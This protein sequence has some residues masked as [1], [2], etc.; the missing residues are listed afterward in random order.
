MATRSYRVRDTITGEWRT[1]VET[2]VP[3]FAIT[4][5]KPDDDEYP[6]L[7]LTGTEREIR[8]DFAFFLSRHPELTPETYVEISRRE[9]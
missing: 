4:F 3:R 9:I 6:C 2:Y 1:V 5:A 8:D 7:C